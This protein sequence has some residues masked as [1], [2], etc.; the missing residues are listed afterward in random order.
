MSRRERA[1]LLCILALF[2]F[3]PVFAWA[4]EL[5]AGDVTYLTSPSTGQVTGVVAGGE[6]IDV[7][8]HAPDAETRAREFLSRYGAAFGLKDPEGELFF[9]E[10]ETDTLGMTHTR[11]GQTYKGIEILGA[12]LIVHENR[13]GKVKSASGNVALDIEVNVTPKLSE[14]QAI[15]TAEK[16]FKNK[17]PGYGPHLGGA[18]LY[19]LK[20]SLYDNTKD[21]AAYLVYK[22][23]FSAGIAGDEAY[24]VDAE[25]GDIRLTIDNLKRYDLNRKV[26]DCSAKYCEQNS[27]WSNFHTTWEI[28]PE[29]PYGWGY[30][31]PTEYTFGCWETGGY[32]PCP[33]GPNPRYPGETSQDTDN[34]F[35]MLADIHQYYW[36]KFQLN[37]ANGQGGNTNGSKFPLNMDVGKGYLEFCQSWQTVC[38][39]AMYALASGVYFCKDVV[40]PD[41]LGHEYAHGVEPTRLLYSG[42]PGSLEENYSDVIGEMFEYWLTGTNDWINGATVPG[43]QGLRN[44]ADPPS[45]IH[46]WTGM[47]YPD[48]YTSDNMYCGP[49]AYLAMYHNMTVPSKAHYLA[50]FEASVGSKFF[51]GC[52]I[53]GIDREKV[54]KIIHRLKTVYYVY[55]ET[56]NQAYNHSLLACADLYGAESA[57]CYEFKKALQAVEMDQVGKCQD[58]NH[59]YTRYPY[60]RCED[61]DGGNSPNIYGV[62]LEAGQEYGDYC[63]EGNQLLEYYC[64]DGVKYSQVHNCAQQGKECKNGRCQLRTINSKEHWPWTHKPR[65]EAEPLP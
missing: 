25:T 43:L 34:L 26:Y 14:Y 10:K 46:E 2:A 42:E 8:P 45:I 48:R 59:Q 54:E 62:V 5:K 18:K 9:K 41:V 11:F 29:N 4:G 47:P 40:V 61:S 56:F 49:D 17:Y 51:N 58:P 35:F 44:L 24:F 50:T 64:L 12:E 31:P 16:E 1:V 19:I 37:G 38:P 7:S 53:N 52:T 20:P 3:L 22:V 6:G 36:D 13:G 55:S 65:L 21:K 57:D 60:C 27:C 39:T 33:H 30:Y 23:D 28:T 32:E 63:I 15:L